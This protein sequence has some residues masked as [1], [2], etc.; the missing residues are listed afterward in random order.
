[1]YV[2]LNLTWREW[3]KIFNQEFFRRHH[4]KLGI[5]DDK[6]IIGSSNLE[7]NYGSIKYGNSQFYDI[8]MFTSGYINTN[9]FKEHFI[10]I[11]NQYKIRL[12]PKFV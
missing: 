1:M 4:E 9:N 7:S 2:T 12:N 10:R 3:W 11:A 8:N 6:A 5:I